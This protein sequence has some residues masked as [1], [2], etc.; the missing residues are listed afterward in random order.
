MPLCIFLPPKVIDD[1]RVT[2]AG[3][4]NIQT[5]RLVC[6]TLYAFLRSSVVISSSL[7]MIMLKKPLKKLT[8]KSQKI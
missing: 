2:C 5:M 8:L 4:G 3:E 7:A 1:V 6:Y